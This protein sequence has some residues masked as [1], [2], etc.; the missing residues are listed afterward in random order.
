MIFF[1]KIFKNELSIKLSYFFVFE[2]KNR[3]D[4]DFF[5][6]KLKNELPDLKIALIVEYKSI[7][8]LLNQKRLILSKKY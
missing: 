7:L 8:F 4:S 3:Q 1:N 5:Q 6:Q 2:R